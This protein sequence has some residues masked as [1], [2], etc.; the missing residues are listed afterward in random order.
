[1]MELLI[2]ALIQFNT[3]FGTA[4]AQTMASASTEP[5]TTTTTTTTGT[6]P[7]TTTTSTEAGGHG[8]GEGH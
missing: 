5:S 6:T 2:A 1:M 8:W 7:P 4:P 3:L